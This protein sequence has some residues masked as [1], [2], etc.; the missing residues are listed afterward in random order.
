MSEWLFRAFYTGLSNALHILLWCSWLTWRFLFRNTSRFFELFQPMIQG[1]IIWCFSP[2]CNL[3]HLHCTVTTDFNSAYHKTN[4]AFCCT[5]HISP[6]TDSRR[7][8]KQGG[9]GKSDRRLAHKLYRLINRQKHLT[10]PRYPPSTEH[11][12]NCCFAAF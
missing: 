11:I 10:V 7:E 9:F 1:L 12:Q 3:R 4:S 2:G 5:V 6:E 8:V